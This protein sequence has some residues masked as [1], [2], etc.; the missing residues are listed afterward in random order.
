MAIVNQKYNGAKINLLHQVLQSDAEEGR[1]REYDIIVDDL[2]VVRRTTDPDKFFLHEDFISGETKTVI[3]TIYEGTSKRSTRYFFALKEG[4]EQEKATLSGIENVMNEKMLQQR[5][6]WEYE[7]LQK[8]L[9]ELKEEMDEQEAY[10]EKL[11]GLLQ[12]EKGKKVSLKDNWGDL[13][14]VALEGMVR[15]N[16]HLLGNIP[17]I[18]QGLAG[19][20]EQDNKRLD[21]SLQNPPQSDQYESKVVFKRV[22]DSPEEEAAVREAMLRPALSKEDEQAL[23]YFKSLQAHFT[24]P[25]LAQLFEIIGRLSHDKENLTDVLELLRDEGDE[26]ND[27][28]QTS[29]A[30]DSSNQHSTQPSRSRSVKPSPAKTVEGSAMQELLNSGE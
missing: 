22:K 27:E 17:M 16:S 18:G 25:E 15:R 11:E 30:D 6:A 12:E 7:Q 21:A 10:V 8:E 23:N 20:V 2:K 1:P 13:M 5:K 14:G 29:N 26:E 19:V 9:E 28:P 24:E 3:I 4:E